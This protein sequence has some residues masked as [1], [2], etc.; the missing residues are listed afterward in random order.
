MAITTCKLSSSSAGAVAYQF[1]YNPKDYDARDDFGVTSIDILHG[2]P[3]YQRISFDGRPRIMVWEHLSTAAV[4]E[5]MIKAFK[6]RAGKMYWIQFNSMGNL[7]H[8]W[9]NYSSNTSW[10][11]MRIIDVKLRTKPGGPGRYESIELWL[12]PQQ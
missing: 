2:A 3:A 7:N 9:P 1:A 6:G 12:G 4:V 8:F 10:Y 5:T 11:R